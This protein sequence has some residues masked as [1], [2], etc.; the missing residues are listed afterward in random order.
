[1]CGGRVLKDADGGHE[2]SLPQSWEALMLFA[3]EGNQP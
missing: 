3:A 1:M 2:K